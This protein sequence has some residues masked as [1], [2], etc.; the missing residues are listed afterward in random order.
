MSQYELVMRTGPAPGKVFALSNNEFY[1]GRDVNNEIVIN[2]TEV[3]RRH[4]HFVLTSEGYTV[5]DLGSTNGT[6]VD[7]NRITGKQ[8][9]KP[10]AMVRL[11][12]NV[13][14]LYQVAGAGAQATVAARGAAPPPPP[15]PPPAQQPAPPAASYAGQV[16][17]SPPK[18]GGLT[19]NR[20][21]MVGC[22]VLLVVGACVAIGLLWYIDANYL[23]CDVFGGLIPACR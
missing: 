9:L 18:K 10:G 1:I 11:G 14:L 4:C 17:D 16:P 22:G 5:E 7:Q 15:P 2:D 19:G 20:N 12:D 8:L 21:L 3:S 23:W 13:T 6:F